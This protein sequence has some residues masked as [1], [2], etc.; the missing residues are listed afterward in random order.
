MS[1]TKTSTVLISD[2]VSA[3]PFVLFLFNFSLNGKKYL[4]LNE[5]DRHCLHLCIYIAIDYTE[6]PLHGSNH[7]SP[8]MAAIFPL[9]VARC[10]RDGP[11]SQQPIH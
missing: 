6:F 11:D 9:E 10:G 1:F 2:E 5:N 8:C 4:V 7:S 3:D